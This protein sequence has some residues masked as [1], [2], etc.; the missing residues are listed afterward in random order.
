MSR[1]D[2]DLSIRKYGDTYWLVGE[3]EYPPDSIL[4]GEY[5]LEKLV[6]YDTLEEAT[7][8]NPGVEIDV[9][10]LPTWF[11]PGVSSTPPRDFDPG[12]AGESWD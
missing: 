8:A 6:P 12:F 9:P 2:L 11:F 7:H 4:A 1:N 10:G 5:K 3:G